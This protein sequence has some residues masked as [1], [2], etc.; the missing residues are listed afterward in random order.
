M[1]SSGCRLT[2]RKHHY[3]DKDHRYMV[4]VISSAITN[5]P[6]PKLVANFL[7]SFNKKHYLDDHTQE[8]LI[9]MFKVWPD[10]T[11]KTVNQTT[12]PARNYCIIE[13]AGPMTPESR[14]LTG[15]HEKDIGGDLGSALQVRENAAG[16][17]SPAPLNGTTR[18]FALDICIRAEIDRQ[19]LDG[20]TKAYK[21]SIPALDA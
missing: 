7:N 19:D 5:E 13:D 16:G 20:K 11:K 14:S 1:L 10:G 3:K 8:N 18:G 4:N 9:R 15:T 17:S 12:M 6:P 21:F 2:Q